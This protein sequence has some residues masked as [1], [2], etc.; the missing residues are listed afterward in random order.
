MNSG[1]IRKLHGNE[2]VSMQQHPGV[3]HLPHPMVAHGNVNTS[4]YQQ[5]HHENKAMDTS[6][7]HRG[8]HLGNADSLRGRTPVS[9]ASP[10]PPQSNAKQPPDGWQRQ[11][12]LQ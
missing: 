2:Y 4:V 12:V 6:T 8:A 7:N 5:Q 9:Y 3:V 10:H 11:G 1:E